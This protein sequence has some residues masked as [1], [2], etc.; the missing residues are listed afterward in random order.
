MVHQA[1]HPNTHR[2]V[3]AA[4][5][6]GV[7]LEPVTFSESTRTAQDAATAVGVDVRQIVKSLVFG[8]V[9]SSGTVTPVVALVNGAD[10][11]DTS[12]L[13]AACGGAKIKRLDADGVR[14]A[15]G[16]PIGGVAP[17]GYPQSVP[18]F[19]DATLVGLNP[20]WAAAGTPHCNMAITPDELILVSGGTV[21]ELV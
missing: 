6:L 13:S 16:F 21:A 1:F 19:I 14:A 3:D 10:M 8:A 11:C 2:V 18:V 5:A 20:L 12:K 9:D 4:A 17:F 15:T 7:R